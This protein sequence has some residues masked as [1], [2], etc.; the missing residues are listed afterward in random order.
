MLAPVF[1]RADV[2]DVFLIGAGRD[3]WALPA[4]LRAMFRER[5][6]SVDAMTTGSAVRTYN[7]L[8]AKTAAPVPD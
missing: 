4:P 3:P 6:I 1:A 5:S 2:L 7:I 8:L